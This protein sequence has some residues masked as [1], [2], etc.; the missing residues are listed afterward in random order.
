MHTIPS[1]ALINPDAKNDADRASIATITR[2]IVG[3]R[4]R[5]ELIL[6]D[7]LPLAFLSLI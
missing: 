6:P 2:M 7:D 1:T 5:N 3:W 4:A